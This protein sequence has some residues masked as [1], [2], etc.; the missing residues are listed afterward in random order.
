MGLD[1]VMILNMEHDIE[2]YWASLGALDTLG[3]DMRSGMIIRHINHN[4]LDY[5][6]T[7]SVHEA[8]IADGFEEFESFRSKNRSNA[9]W[10]WSYRCALR[11]IVEIDR[12]VLVLI[13]DIIPD[14]NWTRSRF[15][16]LVRE[17]GERRFRIIQLV[18]SYDPIQMLPIAPVITSMLKEGLHGYNDFAVIL[19]AEGATLVLSLY[20]EYPEHHPNVIYSVIRKL[21]DVDPEMRLGMYHTPET[22]CRTLCKGR[23]PSQLDATKHEPWEI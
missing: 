3:F 6:D 9:A 17:I 14:R 8:A 19:N 21:G 16:I 11:K 18:E 2:R 1:H 23:F 15:D 10:T 22:I 13:D 7:K 12:T 5:K 20:K 4:G